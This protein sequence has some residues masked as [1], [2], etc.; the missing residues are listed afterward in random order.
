MVR[1]G[2]E[3]R[4]LFRRGGMNGKKTGLREQ[5][6]AL[7]E[8]AARAGV[9]EAARFF[10]MTPREIGLCLTAAAGAERRSAEASDRTA[11]LT[12]HYVGFAVHAP[13]QYPR[14]PQTVFRAEP[15][16]TAEAMKAVF[17]SMA[18][19]TKKTNEAEERE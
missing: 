13:K 5:F 12:G 4:R 16:M 1:G 6:E 2:A 3:T 7:M 19:P 17:R 8:R 15:E 9:P 14:R 10:H 11:W 18:A